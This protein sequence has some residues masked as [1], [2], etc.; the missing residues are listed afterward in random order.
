MVKSKKLCFQ[1]VKAFPKANDSQIRICDLFGRR[2]IT[3]ARFG[4]NR[5]NFFHRFHA[6]KFVGQYTV[7]RRFKAYK[8]VSGLYE[9]TIAAERRLPPSSTNLEYGSS[10]SEHGKVSTGGGTI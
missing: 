8:N 1:L 10:N 3:I 6:K 4:R 9:V 2:S 7:L 5:T